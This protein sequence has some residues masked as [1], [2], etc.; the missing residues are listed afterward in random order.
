MKKNIVLLFASFVVLLLAGCGSSDEKTPS[1]V[2]FT[3]EWHLVQWCGAAPTEFDAYVVFNEDRTFAI[4]Q[5]IE[6]IDYQTFK[7]QWAYDGTTLSG[8]YDDG[9]PWG[10][11]YEIAVDE[12]GATLTL[13]S[14]TSVAE[15][16]VY[17]REAVPAEIRQ[18]AI[19]ATASRTELRRLL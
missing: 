10:S 1:P 13:T 15:V 17:R 7:G 6:R 8:R 3:G 11:A 4:Y 2:E 14:R 12:T 9:T 18:S 5:Q 16:G 19:S